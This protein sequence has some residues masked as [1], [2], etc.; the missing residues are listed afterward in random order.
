MGR[1]QQIALA[2]ILFAI[3][4]VANATDWY[5][6]DTTHAYFPVVSTCSVSWKK[7][8]VPPAANQAPVQQPSIPPAPAPKPVAA[9]APV[10]VAPTP[11][12]ATAAFQQGLADR[13]DLE[14]WFDQ[15]QGDYHEGAV[16][17]S[18]QRSLPHPGSCA[19]PAMPGAW[20]Q[21]CVAAQKRLALS[22]VRRRTEPDYKRG[23]NS[24][25]A[26]G[27]ENI[28]TSSQ[29][30]P[31]TSDRVQSISPRSEDTPPL[32]IQAKQTVRSNADEN[33]GRRGADLVRSG[34]TGQGDLPSVSNTKPISSPDI[35]ESNGG[36]WIFLIF[37]VFVVGAFFYMLPGIV[38]IQ[39]K[40]KNRTEIFILNILLGWTL[41]LW[42]ALLI[43]AIV[44]QKYAIDAKGRILSSPNDNQASKICPKCAET[45]KAGAVKCRFCQHEFTT[46]PLA[47]QIPERQPIHW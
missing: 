10:E 17:W 31:A 46:E 16:Y 9:S 14:A 2:S 3:S 30:A 43:W 18:G 1:F 47:E 6:C 19:N 25:K 39:K 36:G 45:I 7:V 34:L 27:S 33:L 20:Q 32:P 37:L 21:G 29:G 26:A 12:E 24:W 11:P 22:D 35:V 38:A 28:A 41:L 23:W 40:S 42:A 8:T 44:G 4:P 5:W 13:E 15:S